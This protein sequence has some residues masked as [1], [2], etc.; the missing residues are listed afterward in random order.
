LLNGTGLYAGISGSVQL[1]VTF[2]G[3]APRKTSGAC[4]FNIKP[5][6]SYTSLTGIGKV[7][8]S[9]GADGHP[10]LRIA[11]GTVCQ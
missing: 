4:D 1:T 8:F 10:R 5:H 9:A 6:R 11:H 2:A 7:K 3:I